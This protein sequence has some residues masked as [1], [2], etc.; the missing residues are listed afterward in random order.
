MLKETVPPVSDQDKQIDYL[1]LNVVGYQ[2]KTQGPLEKFFPVE[3][4]VPYRPH[5][6]KLAEG[7]PPCSGS[8]PGT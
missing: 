7:T 1:V 5:K 8:Y 4:L 3:F 2:I 6:G